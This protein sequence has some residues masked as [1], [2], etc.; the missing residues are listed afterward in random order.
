MRARSIL[1]MLAL[2]TI[3]LLSIPGVALADDTSPRVG[4]LEI[5]EGR[6]YTDDGTLILDVPAVDDVGVVQVRAR[7]VGGTWTD[8]PY[9]PRITWTFGDASLLA[10][11]QLNV[12]VMWRDA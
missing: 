3:A 1:P 4:T 8:F 11:Q 5:E 6:G 10:E 12:Q 7:L 9:A 2:P